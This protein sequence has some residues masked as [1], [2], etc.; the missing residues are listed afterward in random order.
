MLKWVK[1]IKEL[2]VIYIASVRRYSGD[3]PKRLTSRPEEAGFCGALDKRYSSGSLMDERVGLRTVKT[4][5]VEGDAPRGL[6]SRFYP[7]IWQSCAP[8]ERKECG[9]W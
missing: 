5:E 9:L 6:K 2:G 4:D 7:S 8:I 1:G 3:A